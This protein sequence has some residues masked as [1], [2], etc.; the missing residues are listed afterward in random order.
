MILSGSEPKS[1]NGVRKM[2]DECFDCD[3]HHEAFSPKMH[4]EF[5]SKGNK[6]LHD[7]ARAAKHPKHH[8]KGM[9]PSQMNPD[10]GPHR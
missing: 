7:E 3:Q 1:L 8:T 5:G 4:P 6:H 2:K 9:M 10:H